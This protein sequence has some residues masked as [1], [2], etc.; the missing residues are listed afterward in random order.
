MIFIETLYMHTMAA[1]FASPIQ[2]EINENIIE[3]WQHINQS[4]HRMRKMFRGAL[5]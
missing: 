1:F 5:V 3:L 4:Y 2:R